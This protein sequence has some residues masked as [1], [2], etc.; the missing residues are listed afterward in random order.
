MSFKRNSYCSANAIVMLIGWLHFC[1]VGGRGDA[2]SL[3][4]QSLSQITHQCFGSL[5]PD[6]PGAVADHVA[7]LPECIVDEP[8][9]LVGRR[10]GN[11]A[12]WT[13]K[14]SQAKLPHAGAPNEQTLF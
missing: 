4:I 11:N 9:L 13:D 1:A 7:D 6:H 5:H 2:R 12:D 10:D 8:D 3:V 14:T